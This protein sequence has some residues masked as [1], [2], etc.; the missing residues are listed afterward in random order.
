MRG[1][2]VNTIGIGHKTVLVCVPRSNESLDRGEM[3]MRWICLRRSTR[4]VG[5]SGVGLH[6]AE[7]DE[8]I[9]V[10]LLRSH[11]LEVRQ[12]V[13][14]RVAQRRIR[15][16]PPVEEAVA[17]GVHDRGSVDNRSPG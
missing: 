10:V 5:G 8:H 14:V 4:P 9:L 3:R 12:R 7:L 17:V 13:I 16:L 2:P 6:V 1:D 11:E 15:V